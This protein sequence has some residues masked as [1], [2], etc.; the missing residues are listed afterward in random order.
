MTSHNS[1]YETIDILSS[2]PP[3][4]LTEMNLVLTPE[5]IKGALASGRRDREAA[6]RAVPMRRCR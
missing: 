5:Q 2:I 4:P 3:E 1:T 6:E